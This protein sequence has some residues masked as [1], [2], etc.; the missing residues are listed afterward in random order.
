MTNIIKIDTQQPSLPFWEQ[1]QDIIMIKTFFYL[2]M[3]IK[4][5]SH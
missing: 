2:E 1:E 3:V 4:L 5:D